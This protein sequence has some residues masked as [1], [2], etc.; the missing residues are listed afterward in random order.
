MKRNLEHSKGSRLAAF[1]AAEAHAVERGGVAIRRGGRAMRRLVQ[2]AAGATLV[3]LALGGAQARA[4]ADESDVMCVDE[5]EE[6]EPTRLLRAASLDVRGEPP[7]ELEF[8]AMVAAEDEGPEAVEALLES[9][10]DEW[11]VSEAFADRFVRLH[12]RLLWNALP[13]FSLFTSGSGLSFVRGTGLYYRAGVV[14]RVHRG[15][16]FQTCLDEPA[17]FDDAGLPVMRDIGGG[18]RAEGYVVVNPYWAPDT[19]V[20]VCAIDAQ[21]EAFSSGGVPCH[22]TRGAGLI[23][24]GCGPNLK[25]CR[26]RE[27]NSMMLGTFTAEIELRMRDI[28]LRDAPYTDLFTSRMGYVN[29][30][31]VHFFRY[32]LPVAEIAASPATT[33]PSLLPDLPFRAADTW[34][35]VDLGAHHSGILTSPAY[36]LRMQTNRARASHYY[37]TFL[38]QPFEPPEGGIPLQTEEDIREPDLQERT[39]CEGCHRVLEPAA[40]HWVR[41][42]ER[43]NAYLSPEVFKAVDPVCATCGTGSFTC[44]PMCERFYTTEVATDKEEPYLGWLRGYQFQDTNHHAIETGPRALVETTIADGRLPR[45]VVSTALAE[46]TGRNRR[47]APVD[48]AVDALTQHFIASGFRYRE[49]M[50]AIILSPEYRRV[51]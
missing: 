1:R 27:T 16:A 35:P 51:R 49:L 19:E 13:D 5:P 32:V 26:T 11:L 10:L 3:L 34:V 48:P 45:C 25:W 4:E 15:D 44:P 28:V 40:S 21:T 46:L 42:L 30:P 8:E 12:R 47:P 24:C 37:D 50:K 38:C 31:L 23:D 14:A 9:L 36:L 43:G 17:E 6:L 22:S 33:D 39:G 7:T 18:R 29:G 20:R 2:A 41:W